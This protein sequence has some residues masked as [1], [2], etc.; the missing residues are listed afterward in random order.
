MK[1]KVMNCGR[2]ECTHCNHEGKCMLPSI[3][4]DNQGKCILYMKSPAKSI[5]AH[6]EIN[7]HTNM[8]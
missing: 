7:E 8:C 3:S 2:Y 5:P 6:D 4:I 1:T